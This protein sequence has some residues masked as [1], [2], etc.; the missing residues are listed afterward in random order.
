MKYIDENEE[1]N[2][3]FEFVTTTPMPPQ[4]C[5]DETKIVEFSKC[6]VSH[7]TDVD[8][9]FHCVGRLLKLN[10]NLNSVCPNKKIAIGVLVFEGNKLVGFKVKELYTGRCRYNECN[11]ISAGEFCFVFSE[12]DLCRCRSFKIRVIAHYT[13]L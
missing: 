3:E 2:N 8:I 13:N 1:L 10:V 9:N 6:E 5:Y 4:C 11:S 12:N 7:N